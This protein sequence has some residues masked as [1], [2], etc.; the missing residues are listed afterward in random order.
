MK[1]TICHIPFFLLVILL[2]CKSNYR[3]AA[4]EIFKRSPEPTNMNV[5]KHNYALDV[6]EGWATAYRTYGGVNYYFLNAP[7]SKAD[8]NTNVN[9]ITE[10]MQN[11]SL[12]I[13][14]A[15]SIESLKRTIPTATIQAEGEIEANGLNGSWYSY[16]M[17]QSGIKASIVS[18]I[19]PKDGIAYVITAGTQL[20]DAS[21]YRKTF[22]AI[23]KSLKFD[24]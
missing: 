15:K 4:D 18:Y 14:K 5:G 17:E 16:T 7:Q 21:R 1:K 10:N 23:A 13:F 11:L 20:E 24:E 2:A 19:F 12:D 3:K 8:P 6:P 9:V 22:D